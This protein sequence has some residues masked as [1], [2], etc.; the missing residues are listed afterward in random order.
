MGFQIILHMNLG[1]LEVLSQEISILHES[2][3]VESLK[4]RTSQPNS[5]IELVF[6]EHGMGKRFP[7]QDRADS[8]LKKE[9]PQCV[10][11]AKVLLEN[12]TTKILSL[13]KTFNLSTTMMDSIIKGDAKEILQIA[14]EQRNRVLKRALLYYATQCEKGRYKGAIMEKIERD[15][16]FIMDTEK[17][18]YET[19]C[20][21]FSI[22]PKE[23]KELIIQSI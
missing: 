10:F 11:D 3:I 20:K 13:I 15:N 5:P 9:F 8:W 17:N 12:F 18:E 2:L 22:W 23:T 4:F 16:L 19:L 14:H 7:W 6:R 1:G 21:I